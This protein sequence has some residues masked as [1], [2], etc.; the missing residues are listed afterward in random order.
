MKR[1]IFSALIVIFGFILQSTFCRYIAFG[2]ISPNLL[3]IITASFGFMMGK[4]AGILTGFFTG[5]LVDVFFTGV[6]G[7]HAL[8][9]MY[10]GYFNGFFKKLFFKDDLKLQI[11]LVTCSDF[12]Y[13]IVYYLLLFLLR[14]KFHMGY[15]LM[16]IIIPEV[17]YTV[18]LTIIV[19]IM[20]T[21]IQKIFD[22]RK[23][24][25]DGEIV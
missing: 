24:R 18:L 1:N 5:L 23:N 15:Y 14:G 13:G 11:L 7:L 10:I 4:K 6:L 3:I 17:V 12:I 9:Y 21:L 8:F 20:I 19:F 2:N 16:N 25:R 22:R